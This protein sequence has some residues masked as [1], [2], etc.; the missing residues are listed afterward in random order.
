LPVADGA[1]EVDSSGLAIELEAGTVEAAVGAM[2][3]AFTDGYGNGRPVPT[4]TTL[5]GMGRIDTDEP[6]VG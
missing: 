4:L 2:T 3:V 6:A 1:A 5:E